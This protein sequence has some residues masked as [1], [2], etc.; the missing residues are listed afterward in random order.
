ML[1]EMDF[2]FR[3]KVSI[4]IK[5]EK[6]KIQIFFVFVCVSRVGDGGGVREGEMGNYPGCNFQGGVFK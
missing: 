2:N 4:K 1:R 3:S 5:F 6:N